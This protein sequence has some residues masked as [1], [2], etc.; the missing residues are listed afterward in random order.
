MT[1]PGWRPPE[2]LAAYKAKAIV[3]S[4]VLAQALSTA[5]VFI[6][7]TLSHLLNSG[8]KPVTTPVNFDNN[9]SSMAKVRQGV[10]CMGGL[11][12]NLL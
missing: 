8:H 11:L 2:L 5:S 1:V 7:A 12:I 4:T 9:G 6:K 10:S 3:K